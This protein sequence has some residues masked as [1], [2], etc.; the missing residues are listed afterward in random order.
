MLPRD[1]A[2]RILEKVLAHSR[3]E[4]ITAA[5]YNTHTYDL[6]FAVNTVTT[7]GSSEGASLFLSSNFGQRTGSV[8][9]TALDDASLEA[10]VRRAEELAH[11][12]PENPEFMP[13]LGPQ[14]YLKIDAYDEE[15]ASA[16]PQYC[17]DAA[18]KALKL[19]RDREVDLSGFFTLGT[20][21]SHFANSSG[22]RAHHRAAQATYATTARTRSGRGSHKVQMASRRLRDLKLD[23]LSGRAIER[24]FEAQNPVALPPGRYPTIL[25]PSA[26]ADMLGF[27]FMHM[28]KRS[29]DEGRSFFSESEGKTK[30]GQKLFPDSVSIGTDPQSQLAPGSPWGQDGVPLKALTWI[31]KGT[32]RN[33]HVDRYWAKKTNSELTPFPTNVLMQG[34][35]KSLAELIEIGR[36]HV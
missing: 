3:A 28:S 31:D 6:R 30:L 11:L 34:G 4:S 33:M 9:T 17:T 26:C 2:E 10:A 20:S 25:E 32:L 7:C 14:E 21:I 12:A 36:A 8:S 35:N 22:L 5:L 15:T 23:E 27:L 29:A 16:S 24:A 1:Q 18:E 19:S 13:P